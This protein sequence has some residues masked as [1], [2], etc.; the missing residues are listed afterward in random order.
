MEELCLM[1]NV[2]SALEQEEFS[3]Y[4]IVDDESITMPLSKEDYILDVTTEFLKNKQVRIDFIL[5]S[6]ILY[7]NIIFIILFLIIRN[8]ISILLKSRFWLV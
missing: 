6:L 3:L 5:I 4:C 7:C 2:R 8:M 1:I